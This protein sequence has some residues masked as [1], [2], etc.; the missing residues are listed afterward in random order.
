MK[1]EQKNTRSYLAL[2]VISPAIADG[3]TSQATQN[4]LTSQQG[5]TLRRI[6]MKNSY[7]SIGKVIKSLFMAT[8]VAG[9]LAACS[10]TPAP[11]AVEGD[12]SQPQVYIVDGV[13]YSPSEMAALDGQ[14]LTLYYVVTPEAFAQGR[15]Y[16][17]T[18][19]ADHLS[20]KKNYKTQTEQGLTAQ[21]KCVWDLGTDTD[22]RTTLYKNTGYGG[23]LLRLNKGSSYDRAALGSFDQTISSVKGACSVW[24]DLYDNGD[25]TGSAWSTFGDN[26]RSLPSWINNDAS[27]VKVGQ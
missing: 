17:F 18:K 11:Q 19:E 20:F 24:T 8:L 2:G 4:P 25:F 22:T 6:E 16:V 15:A 5:K 12:S 10:S 14:G 21:G 13:A 1:K 26:Y 7:T 27:S 3:V 9:F 23:D